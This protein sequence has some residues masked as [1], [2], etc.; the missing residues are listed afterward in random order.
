MTSARRHRVLDKAVDH[1]APGARDAVET[2]AVIRCRRR[3][4][5]QPVG[6]RGSSPVNRMAADLHEQRVV[7]N[8]QPLLRSLHRLIIHPVTMTESEPLP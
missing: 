3:R 2:V 4:P 6:A 1:T 8:P 5:C 7:H